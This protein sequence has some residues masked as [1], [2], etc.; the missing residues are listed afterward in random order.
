[1]P[2]V[3]SFI[4]TSL[5]F[6][7]RFSDAN[8][9]AIAAIFLHLV[10][11]CFVLILAVEDEG[12]LPLN[13]TTVGLSTDIVGDDSFQD[14]IRTQLEE[15]VIIQ[16]EQQQHRQEET[17]RGSTQDQQGE[18]EDGGD[19]GIILP[20]AGRVFP[21]ATSTFKRDAS[22][23]SIGKKL[24]YLFSEWRRTEKK[25]STQGAITS[26]DSTEI[27]NKRQKLMKEYSDICLA[28]RETASPATAATTTE[29]PHTIAESTVASPLDDLF[30]FTP[31]SNGLLAGDESHNAGQWMRVTVPTGRRE[32]DRDDEISASF[33][34]DDLATSVE[35]KSEEDRE[36]TE[37]G[38]TETGH[39]YYLNVITGEIRLDNP[40][41]VTP[42]TNA[43]SNKQP[44]VAVRFAESYRR[45]NSTSQHRAANNMKSQDER[46]AR[47]D[48]SHPIPPSRLDQGVADSAVPKFI[49]VSAN[50]PWNIYKQGSALLVLAW[51][52]A[53]IASIGI[54]LGISFV[55]DVP[56][57]PN[58]QRNS[59]G[60]WS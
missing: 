60:S 42:S 43:N 6:N 57:H 56:K 31:T 15:I 48:P 9:I 26:K 18:E 53:L 58:N 5:W 16:E 11:L 47:K 22:P 34:T 55:S 27:D 20:R 7:S 24:R 41:V 59:N 49:S 30:N 51:V 38:G 40:A 29:C 33:A 45:Y 12:G 25:S 2:P 32:R 10:W 8:I 36:S 28:L 52:L 54:P 17:H 14:Y 46:R 21:S 4:A 50:R 13:F 23:E 3:L 44:P 1:M 35:T 19:Q 37:G 39:D